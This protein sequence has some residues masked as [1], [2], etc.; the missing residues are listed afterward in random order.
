MKEVSYIKRIW[1]VGNILNRRTMDEILEMQRVSAFAMEKKILDLRK[2][3]DHERRQRLKSVLLPAFMPNGTFTSKRNSGLKEYGPYTV[4]D[5]DNCDVERK[6]DI[7]HTPCVKAVYVSPSGNGLKIVVMHDNQDPK[8]HKAMYKKLMKHFKDNYGIE[9]DSATSGLSSAHYLSFD[10]GMLW[11][12]DDE[13]KPFEFSHCPIVAEDDEDE[14]YDEPVVPIKNIDTGDVDDDRIIAFLLGGYRLT[15]KENHTKGHRH[16]A[17]LRQACEMY[18]AGIKQETI[19]KLLKDS[20]ES[21]MD[22]EIDGI[23]TWL[24]TSGIEFGSSRET[25]KSKLAQGTPADLNTNPMATNIT[26]LL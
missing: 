24:E 16:K 5:A 6:D 3:T 14:D 9:C 21:E 12:E 11:R 18:G 23:V 1:N 7:F 19:S 10:A 2:V 25:L 13:V 22:K 20:Y 8:R 17:I 4:L 15:Y 26:D